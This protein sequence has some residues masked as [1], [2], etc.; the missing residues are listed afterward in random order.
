MTLE[1]T[2]AEL[3]LVR[4][5]LADSTATNADLV[6]D[7]Q[8]LRTELEEHRLA[9]PLSGIAQLESMLSNL[10]QENRTNQKE[11]QI[12]MQLVEEQKALDE[13]V[14]RTERD[15]LVDQVARLSS[16]NSDLRRSQREFA[17]QVERSMPDPSLL[18]SQ[19]DTLERTAAVV[20]AERDLLKSKLAESQQEVNSLRSSLQP[21][22]GDVDEELPEDAGDAGFDLDRYVEP[23]SDDGEL[24]DLDDANDSRDRATS[25]VVH[26]DVA[27]PSLLAVQRIRAAQAMESIV[28]TDFESLDDIEVGEDSLHI[29]PAAA[30]RGTGAA[31]A[32]PPTRDALTRA[33]LEDA[34][35]RHENVD[36]LHA[37]M[38]DV[39]PT[40]V[41]ED[42]LA[43]FAKARSAPATIEEEE[44]EDGGEFEFSDIEIAENHL[45]QASDDDDGFADIEDLAVDVAAESSRLHGSGMSIG[46]VGSSAPI[47]APVSAPVTA[48]A[49]ATANRAGTITLEDWQRQQTATSMAALAASVP[50]VQRLSSKPQ[51]AKPQA[52]AAA[53]APGLQRW[54]ETQADADDG[55]DWDDDSEEQQPQ[56]RLPARASA[57]PAADDDDDMD[58]DFEGLDDRGPLAMRPPPSHL[59]Q[60]Q[61]DHV[62]LQ[63]SHMPR[64]AGG[65]NVE[66]TSPSS[67]NSDGEPRGDGLSISELGVS[68]ATFV[69]RDAPLSPVRRPRELTSSAPDPPTPTTRHSSASSSTTSA[70]SSRLGVFGGV[71]ASASSARVMM[72]SQ[73]LSF[74][75]GRSTVSARGENGITA[76]PRLLASA[77][78]AHGSSRGI[79]D[80]ADG[81]LQG[82]N[83]LLTP[84]ADMGLILTNQAEVAETQLND[85]LNTYLY[86]LVQTS[87]TRSQERPLPPPTF[88]QQSQPASPTPAGTRTDALVESPLHTSDEGRR[89]ARRLF[90]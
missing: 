88:P 24:H 27:S 77:Q 65:A 23:I 42:A 1:S 43:A 21:R 50:V 60:L 71:M 73:L 63:M 6:S 84:R 56:A 40:P 34:A 3:S 76:H 16:V 10:R 17:T 39:P 7:N 26:Q 20:A 83:Y 5:S 28:E 14:L 64:A 85:G 29:A 66:R 22:V 78:A 58:A 53:A 57:L 48:P 67:L 13:S 75:S 62:V 79:I 11:R 81:S 55:F 37:W 4:Q 8:R 45:Q 54:M 41:R 33:I 90:D 49:R 32:A 25:F 68:A 36:S 89:S 9:L 44:E 61:R 18:R 87:L 74:T 72:P 38:E 30:A 52:P 47:S 51:A 46:G 2:S 69:S 70:N 12:A 19:F 82:S 35:D 86:D 80:I 31:P 15:M 59:E